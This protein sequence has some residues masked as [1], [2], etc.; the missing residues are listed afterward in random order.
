F[1]AGFVGSGGSSPVVAY[2]KHSIIV[3]FPDP[4]GPTIIVR[5]V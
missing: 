4:L 3:V 1:S 2:F 5:G